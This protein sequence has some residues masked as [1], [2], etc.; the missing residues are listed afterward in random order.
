MEIGNKLGSLRLGSAATAAAAVALI[1]VLG[2]D[3]FGRWTEG[4][5]AAVF[6][7][8]S[9]IF[10]LQSGT[11]LP[12]VFQ[13][14]LEL[15]VIV[16]V[17]GALR[18]CGREGPV[19]RPVI[20]RLFAGGALWGV[21][22]F[23]RPYDGMLLLV[24][25]VA[26][27]AISMR[28]Q[29]RLLFAT[30]AWGALGAV[31]PIVAW[32]SF[33]TVLMG[34]PLR[35]TFTITGPTDQLGFG[36][37][38]VFSTSAFHFTPGDGR[39]SFE[40][41]LWQ[42][43]GWSFGG[44]LL[45]ALAL[46][47]LWR[48]RRTGLELWVILGLAASFAIGYAFFWSPYSIVKLWP[49]SDTMGPF[50]HL[51][52]LVPLALLGAA[53]LGAILD[54]N[55]VLGVVTLLVLVAVTAASVG[56]KV[57]R[58]Q[59]VTRRYQ[60]VEKLVDQAHLKHAVLFVE[61]RGANGFESAS[62]FL[63]NRPSLGQSVIYALDDGAADLA[64]MDRFPNRTG[65]VMRTEHRPGDPLLKPT[66]FVE[67]LH[68][69]RASTIVLRFHVVNTTGSPVVLSTLHV[70]GVTRTAVL[71]TSSSKNAAYDIS[72]TLE[73]PA[74]GANSG[75]KLVVP[76]TNGSV[77]VEADFTSPGRASSRYQL[78]YW[79]SADHDHVRL[80]GPGR[81]RYLFQYQAPIWLNQDINPTLSEAR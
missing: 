68:V 74:L 72:W 58:N 45:V 57:D 49:G 4:L 14:V 35:N 37:R 78:Q 77:E 43:P 19:T 1:G 16:L 12:Y 48:S 15:S 29:P 63:E 54:R 71:D 38:G 3:M 32:L 79:Y 30:A 18:R 46:F 52:I 7:A 66:R 9:P 11:Y 76:S 22:C 59:V 55:R 39:V 31:V 51:P 23:A 21:A 41:N 42:F 5:L 6:L 62:P 70:G 20:A 34:S 60:A 10:F 73:A 26:T 75:T 53:G 65:A 61:D 8:L 24:P 44:V 36:L 69:E 33:N 80:L 17:C 81:G 28:R 64:V 2:R 56:A 50:Y 13:L 47:G 40:Q 27:A 67:R 25:I